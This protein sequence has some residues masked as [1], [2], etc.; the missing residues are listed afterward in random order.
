[1]NAISMHF[2]KVVNPEPSLDAGPPYYPETLIFTAQDLPTGSGRIVPL[3]CDASR[4]PG[5][6]M[7]A[8]AQWLN[9]FAVFD[10]RDIHGDDW[11]R[12]KITGY[13]HYNNP[14]RHRSIISDVYLMDHVF[15]NCRDYTPGSFDEFMRILDRHK[16]ADE[17]FRDL[18]YYREYEPPGDVSRLW[19]EGFRT[20]CH[21]DHPRA[22]PVVQA[23]PVVVSGAVWP[24][25]A[26]AAPA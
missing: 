25:A 14:G 10:Q 6:I 4:K 23:V 21:P 16:I 5:E 15:S 22:H 12:Y 8:I 20:C 26:A 19:L 2:H 11:A 18:L 7:N 1:M 3:V 24:H 17:M 13:C 9:D